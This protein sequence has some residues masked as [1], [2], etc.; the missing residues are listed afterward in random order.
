MDVTLSCVIPSLGRTT[1][2]RTLL[3]VAEQMR[4]GDEILVQ[5]AM[6]GSH[7]GDIER[8][9]AIPHADGTHLCFLDDDD[10]Y[11]PGALDAMRD[12]ACDV[13]TIFRMK[14]WAF[15]TLWNEPTL[16]FGNVS[17]QMLLVP[18]TPGKL[19]VWAPHINTEGT[20]YTFIAKTCSLMGDAVWDERVIAE[21]RPQ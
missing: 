15:E 12:R 3:S 11:L 2:L 20:D 19:G 16:R 5:S 17:T 8:N 1:L 13:P 21:A 4:D 7:H 6:P 9:H 18:N 10:V 14:H